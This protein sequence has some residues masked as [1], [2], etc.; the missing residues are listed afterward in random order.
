MV[1]ADGV[2]NSPDY[3]RTCQCSYQNQTSL[4]L[5]NMPWMSYWT[6]SD[7]HWNGSSIRQLGLNFNAPGDRSSDDN[8]LW[9]ECPSV[10][11]DLP[12]IPVKMD[13]AG[14]Y[15]IRKEPVSIISD[16]T[17]WVSASA[18]G[19][20]SSVEITLSGDQD[21]QESTYTVKLYFAELE[22]KAPGERVFDI[23]IQGDKVSGSFD[24]VREAGRPDKE[25]VRSFHGIKAGKS[26][27]IGLTPSTGATL[28]CGIEILKE[29]LAEK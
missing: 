7:Y 24:I 6:N 20:I 23:S 10:A 15:R 17:P 9:F 16:R 19:G 25:V 26:I 11:G 12:G 28:I 22:N 18:L 1:A 4:A 21:V 3:T 2:L 8:V 5:I 13:S 29:N 14:V 27:I